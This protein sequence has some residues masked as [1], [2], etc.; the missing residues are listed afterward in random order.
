MDPSRVRP[1]WL[2]LP[3]FACRHPRNFCGKNGVITMVDVDTTPP[4]NPSLATI[5]QSPHVAMDRAKGAVTS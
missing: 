5:N 1:A 3:R 4:S 2:G